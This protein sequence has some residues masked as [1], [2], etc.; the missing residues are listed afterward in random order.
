MQL[1]FILISTLFCTLSYAS[2]ISRQNYLELIKCY[3]HLIQPTGDFSKGE[4]QVVLDPDKMAEIEKST[5]RD[6]GVVMKDKYWLWIND[7]CIFPNGN[8]GV[9]GRILWVKALESSPGVAVM[10]V[11][12]DGK[13]V[14]NCNFRHS[15]RSWEIE[16]PRGIVNSGE[17]LEAA[18][19]RETMEETGMV[20]DELYLLG[21]IPPDTGITST[22]VPI[23]AAKVKNRQDS[24]QED[25]EAIEEILALS[26]NEIKKAFLQGYYECTIRG[27]SKRVPFRDPFL[28]YAILIYEN[29]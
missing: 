11:L 16:L 7:A 1:L 24:Q 26:I 9:Y 25:T 29:K 19:R 18:A 5:A 14:L 20:V 12:P 22:V 3:P 2:E 13:I 4:I 27:I 8:T 6:V 23:F 28:A 17:E 15:T 10:P 21:E